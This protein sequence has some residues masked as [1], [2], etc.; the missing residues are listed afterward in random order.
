MTELALQHGLAFAYLYD[1]DALVRLD[2]AF[3]A[4]LA[5]TDVG[6]YDRLMAA[7]A[8]PD[9][10]DRKGESDLLVDL[11]PYL[12]DYIGELFGISGQVR[13]LQARHDKL[14]P[15]FSVKRLFVQRRAVK[16]IKEADAALLNGHKLAQELETL[17]GGPPASFDSR[18]GTLAWELRYAEAVGRWLD[19]EAAHQ[20]PLKA[21][22]EYAAWA[23]LASEGQKKHRRG[24]LFRVPHRLDMHH[25]VPVETVERDGVTMLRLPE[26]HWRPRDGFA[27]TDPGTDLAGAMDQA[28]YC[29]WCHNQQKDS[30]RTG[31]HEKDG[32]FKKT[33]FGVT[34]AGCPLD[35]NISEMNIVKARG[36]SIGALA[37]VAVDNPLCAATG[38][39]ICNDCMKSCIYQRQEPVDIPQIETRTLKDVLA[40][41]WGFEIYSLLT[42][43]NPLDLRRPLPKPGSGHKV[44]VVGLGPAGFNLAHH[45]INDGYFV[46]AIDGLKIEPL[47]AEISGVSPTGE[48]VPFA[49]VHDIASLCE[50]L[51]ERTMAGFGGVAEYGITVRW[52]KNFLKMIR[53]LL[54]RRTQ[55]AMYGG[56]RFGGTLTIDSAFDLGFDHIAL[57]A[58]AGRP[59]VIPMKNNL[60]PGVRQASDFLMALQLTGAAKTDSIANLTVRLPVVV[61]GGGLTAIDTATEALAY[62]PLQVEK[63][64]ARYETLAAERGAEAVRADWNAAEREVAEEFIAHARAIRA[65]REAA[66]RDGRPPRL[67][68]LIDSWGGVTIAYRRR[69]IDAPSY[70]LNH[71]EVAKAMEEGIRFA[72][73][74]TPVAVEVDVF[75]QAAALRMTRHA[76]EDVGG[77]RPEPDQSPGEELVLP[78]RTILVAA[79]TQPNTVLARE[80]PGHVGLDGRYFRALDEDGNPATP[81][82]VAKPE[83]VRVLIHLAEDGRA[84]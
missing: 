79:G 65:E 30:C 72:E 8:E 59:T 2:R 50:R 28:N 51:D 81:E 21:A 6:L 52:D 62:Y 10:L 61:I 80:D 15:L 29:I 38:H 44:L 22:L 31:L 32:G 42:R 76:A 40:L 55:F 39:R 43:W 84:V 67:A 4:H 48:R 66:T 19:D 37:I 17:I 9:G 16:E 41:P 11:A 63:F 35:E 46:A 77:H 82:R 60:A 54:E 53:L 23:T 5:S 36:N 57:C 56:V 24:L 74:L 49:P 25:L 73:R 18:E 13:E 64:L 68:Q 45:L 7:R 58:G 71:E 33:V 3:V 70:T 1:R 34:L 75:E 14:A 27:L 12:E 69:L 78:A 83:A 20:L 26:G 47:S